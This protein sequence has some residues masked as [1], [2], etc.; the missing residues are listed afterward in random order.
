MVLLLKIDHIQMVLQFTR[1]C[2]T[3]R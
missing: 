3:I 2:K 1:W